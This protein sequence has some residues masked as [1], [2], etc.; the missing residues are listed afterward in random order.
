MNQNISADMKKEN[1]PQL[2]REYSLQ[3]LDEK[4]VNKDPFKQ[5]E[6]WFSEALSLMVK[7]A[8]AMTL[9][10]AGKDK[11]PHARIVL[12][13]EVTNEGFVFYTN[14]NSDKG[15]EMQE[16]PN[17]AI[18]FYWPE[19]ERQVRIEGSVMKIPRGESEKYFRSRPHKSQIGALASDQSQ[20]VKNRQ[21]LE[22]RFAQLSKKY[23]EAEVPMPEWWGGY[24]LKPDS[25][26]FWQGRESRL[27]D[28][29]K[30]IANGSNW[31][32]KRLSP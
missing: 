17:A 8:N 29:I 14:Y 27:H 31:Q 23:G 10:T 26:E 28:R 24:V 11:K 20:E 16:N 25:I 32:I 7:D 21:A 22:A 30:Y 15:R 13:K 1:L 6:K 18:C 12:L 19:L 2:R 4:E 9:A 5:F 3:A